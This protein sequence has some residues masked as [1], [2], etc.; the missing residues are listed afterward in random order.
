MFVELKAP[1]CVTIIRFITYILEANS[2]TQVCTVNESAT[3]FYIYEYEYVHYVQL[4][5]YLQAPSFAWVGKFIQKAEEETSECQGIN[6]GL[7]NNQ[8]THG[9]V[10]GQ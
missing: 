1:I 9:V 8:A 10:E 5:V 2:Y 3:R 4:Q 6:K 7:H